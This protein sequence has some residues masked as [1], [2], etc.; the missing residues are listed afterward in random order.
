MLPNDHPRAEIN[1]DTASI[2]LPT[3]TA[4]AQRP[5]GSSTPSYDP[6][7]LGAWDGQ[8]PHAD[9]VDQLPPPIDERKLRGADLDR[10]EWRRSNAAFSGGPC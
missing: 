10:D 9:L 8:L 2:T 5:Q 3:T 7:N 1:S 6:E 4:Q